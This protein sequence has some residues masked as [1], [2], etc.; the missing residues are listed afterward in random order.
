MVQSFKKARNESELPRDKEI[1]NTQIANARIKLE[2][3]IGLLKGRFQILRGM[4]VWIRDGKKQVKEVVDI[5]S[6]CCILHNLLLTY[7][8]TIP[9]EWYDNLADHIDFSQAD[10]IENTMYVRTRGEENDDERRTS[11]CGAIWIRYE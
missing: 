6:S 4:N 7:N 1:F 11:V 9:Q 8:N 2:H 5:F 3:C 10:E